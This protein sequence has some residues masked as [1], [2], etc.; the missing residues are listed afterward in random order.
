MN[1]NGQ[2]TEPCGTPACMVFHK[3]LPFR[4]TICFL[5]SCNKRLADIRTVGIND[6]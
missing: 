2:R 3:Y 5:L 1:I 4:T 6:I